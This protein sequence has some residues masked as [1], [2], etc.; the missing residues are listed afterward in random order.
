MNSKLETVAYNRGYRV[1]ENGD[2]INPNGKVLSGSIRT[3]NRKYSQLVFTLKI[4]GKSKHCGVH[5]LQAYQKYGDKIYDI[6][7]LVRHLDGNPMNN[8]YNNIVIGSYSDNYYDIPLE[9]GKT[10]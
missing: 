2:I 5:R 9:K 1:A 4:D 7:V 6:R 3:P 10:P 8:S